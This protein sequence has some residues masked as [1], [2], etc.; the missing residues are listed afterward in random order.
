MAIKHGAAPF[1][2]AKAR[3]VVWTFPDPVPI[4]REPLYTS[5]RDLVADYPTYKDTKAYRLP[6]MYES[7]QKKDFSKEYPTILT[8]GRLVEYEGGG[9]ESRSNPWLA[10]LQ[11]EMF[12]EVNPKDANNLGVR[13]GQAV[14]VHGAEGAKVKVKAMLTERVAPGVAF[15][16]FHFAGHF[17]GK[18][19]RDKYPS[20]SDPYVLGEAAN[21]AMTYGY[22]SVTQM[23][24]SKVTLCRIEAA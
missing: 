12:V 16:P 15:M 7:I 3:T 18:D 13:D 19:L 11:Q 14:W 23:Q 1:G 21:T 4:H 24:E 20:G 22:D 17:Q 9:D 5:R 8:S 2:N 10:E 6:T